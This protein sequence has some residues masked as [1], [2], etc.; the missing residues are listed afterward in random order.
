MNADL[1]RRVSLLAVWASGLAAVS[2]RPVDGKTDGSQGAL[3]ARKVVNVEVLAVE[4]STFSQ[5]VRVT[6]EVEALG[7]V[8]VSAEEGGVVREFYVEKGAGVERGQ[9]VAKI[10]DAVLAAQV[11]EARAAA[12]VAREQYERQ[13]AVWGESK[14]GSEIALLQAKAQAEAAEARLAGLE[15]RL[16]KTVIRSPLRGVLDERYL[17]AGEMA[18]VGSPVARVVAAHKL[19]VVAGVPERFAPDIRVGAEVKVTFDILPGREYKA[20][21]SFVGASVDSRSRTF[22]IEAVLDNPE[23]VIKPRMLANLELVRKKLDG[24]IAIPQ[25]AV[26]RTEKGYQ[27]FVTVE[28]LGELVAEPREVTLGPAQEDVV[29]IQDGISPGDRVIIVGSRL[30]D[31]GTRVRVVGNSEVNR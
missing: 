16:A 24:V 1:G 10:D 13:R 6:G 2:C 19:K 31:P 29:V 20:V 30:V 17:D 8:I 9:P 3:E 18:G 11:R 21:V 12:A 26:L 23:G 25:S 14:V 15:A 7:D 5:L 28:R 27:V 22:P 4:P